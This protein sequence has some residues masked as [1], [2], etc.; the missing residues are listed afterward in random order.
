MRRHYLITGALALL[1]ALGIAWG[2]GMKAG[3]EPAALYAALCD[4][5]FVVGIFLVCMGV[6][7]WVSTT[8]FFDSLSYGFQGLWYRLTAFVR[9]RERQ[10]YYDYKMTREQRRKRI[11]RVPLLVGA[12]LLTLSVAFLLLWQTAS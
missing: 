9:D 2:R 3:A 1:T 10:T 7:F 8:G 6:L 5:F 12:A 11:H 4:G